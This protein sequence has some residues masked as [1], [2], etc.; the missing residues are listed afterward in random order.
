MKKYRA[1][2]FD[3]FGT[4]ALFDSSKL[5]VFEWN[6]QTS[7]STMGRLRVVFEE[8]SPKTPFAHFCSALAEVSKTLGEER[9]RSMREFSSVHRFAQTLLRLGFAE[10]PA[11]ARL[12]EDLALAHMQMLASVTVVPTAHLEFLAQVRQRYAVA[13]VSNFDHGPTARRIL[14]AG[15][16]TDYFQHILVSDEH[17]WR[18][19]HPQIFTDAL[20][21]LGVSP[22][23]ALF[24]GDS[25]HD[26]IAGAKTVGMDVAW[27]NAQAAAL[28]DQ[29]AMPEYT[30]KAIPELS[31]LLF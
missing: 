17:G 6:G 26:D 30:I 16:V 24:V 13:L 7:R 4:V 11:T 22:T 28:P 20:A 29:T 25:L 9:T 15:G 8:K 1:V 3:L 23:E 27:V 19:P 18:K 12:A 5:P 31:R 2:L 10:S 14:Q 21:L